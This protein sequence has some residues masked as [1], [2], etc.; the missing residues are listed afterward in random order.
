MSRE[1][2]ERM[3][4]WQAGDPAAFADLVARWQ[5]PVARFL[6]RLAGPDRAADLC[7]EVFLRV[8][9]KGNRYRETGHFS[10]WLFQIALNVA[11]GAGRRQISQS[12]DRKGAE[13]A[14]APIRSRLCEPDEVCERQELARAVQVA[15]AELPRP[16]REVLALRHDRGMNFEEMARVLGTPAST[17]KSRF[18]AALSRLRQRL[19][20][21]GF[22]PEES[23]P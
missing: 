16:L 10:T 3:R 23:A 20:E 8:L 11:R 17:L 12:R 18:A 7:Q 21:L 5:Q 2:A 22:S 4:R 15:V 14:S 13:S 1:D 9:Q 6:A 19:C